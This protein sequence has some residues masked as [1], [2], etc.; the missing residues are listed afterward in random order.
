M[1]HYYCYLENGAQLTPGSKVFKVK[2]GENR[3]DQAKK[4]L[5]DC[6]AQDTNGFF[7]IWDSTTDF[8]LAKIRTHLPADLLSQN[9][10]L[11]VVLCDIQTLYRNIIA[12]TLSTL[13][14]QPSVIQNFL[15]SAAI[16]NPAIFLKKTASQKNLSVPPVKRKNLSVRPT[17]EDNIAA[18]GFAILLLLYWLGCL[19]GC[20]EKAVI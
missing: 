4:V 13:E 16:L 5:L 3:R 9:F 15:R 11:N 20:W 6:Y 14:N 1:I 12:G 19:V 17:D 7:R 8:H 2:V 10:G 18:A